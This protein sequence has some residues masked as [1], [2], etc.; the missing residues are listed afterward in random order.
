MSVT[1][2][3]IEGG[4]DPRRASL[5]PEDKGRAI[6]EAEAQRD[7]VR[8]LLRSGTSENSVWAKFAD[9]DAQEAG[10]VPEG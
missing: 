6:R 10:E 9:G 7:G 8:R 1:P 4:R 5:A 3:L 2:Q